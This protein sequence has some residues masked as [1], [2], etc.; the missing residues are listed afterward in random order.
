M[1]NKKV[2]ALVLL[3]QCGNRH[4]YRQ[5]SHS[6]KL[7][8]E[9][10]YSEKI[11]T[12]F[13]CIKPSKLNSKVKFKMKKILII[14]PQTMLLLTSTQH[15]VY[16]HS[17]YRFRLLLL[18]TKLPNTRLVKTKTIFTPQRTKIFMLVLINST[19]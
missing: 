10:H 1:S 11:F 17:F 13:F 16:F 4:H 9:Y 19:K 5:V 2:A 8:S 7:H 3:V 14:A 15:R 18:L 6:A 12:I